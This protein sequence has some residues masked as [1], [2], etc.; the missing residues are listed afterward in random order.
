M[1]CTYGMTRFTLSIVFSF[2]NK[3]LRFWIQ[4]WVALGY[5]ILGTSIIALLFTSPKFQFPNLVQ[6]AIVAIIG[7]IFALEFGSLIMLLVNTKKLRNVTRVGIERTFAI[8]FLSRYI[9]YISLAG[10]PLIKNPGWF[11]PVAVYTGLIMINLISLFWIHVVQKNFTSLALHENLSAILERLGKESGI[12]KREYE[13]LRLILDGKSNKEIEAEP[14]ISE[15]TVKNH[16]Y[17]LYQKLGI[18]S[19]YQLIKL[20]FAH[21]GGQVYPDESTG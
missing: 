20:L 13:V 14:F 7:S 6:Y 21:C 9:L 18:N 19:R 16:I 8:L 12:S 10:M 15:H 1:L 3:P 2:L 17:N 4:S 5:I 11:V